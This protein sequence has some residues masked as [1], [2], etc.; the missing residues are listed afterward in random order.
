MSEFRS[1]EFRTLPA[2]DRFH[3]SYIPEPNSGCWLWLGSLTGSGYARFSVNTCKMQASRYSWEL[4][5]GEIP[6]GLLVCHKCDNRI[7]VNPEHL[8]VGTQSD[9]LRDMVNKGR[10][11]PRFGEGS[12]CSRFTETNIIT[13]RADQ[14][15]LDVIGRSY[16]VDK[17]YIWKIKKGWF[18]KHL[19]LNDAAETHRVS[20]GRL[21]RSRGEKHPKNK[22]TALQVLAIRSDS[23]G[24]VFLSRA[25]G[26]SKRTILSI[27]NRKIWKHV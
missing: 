10:D 16:G 11:N 24:C 13:I 12:P 14:R 2:V 9:N 17:S 26:V 6:K 20:N 5:F 3:K 23:R 19:P 1:Y 18:W 4:A 21:I 27:K 25:Y 7:C 22:L 15:P 8:F